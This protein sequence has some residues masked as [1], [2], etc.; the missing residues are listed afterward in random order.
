MDVIECE[1]CGGT[2]VFDA[3]REYARCIFCASVALRPEELDEPPP[4]PDDAVPFAVPGDEAD[5]T[6]RHW[7]RSSW[8]YPKALR[9][10]EI[11][12]QPLWIPAWRF[13]AT[14]EAHYAGLRSAPTRSGKQ[15]L[16]GLDVA[17][18]R[19][20]APASLGLHEDELNALAPFDEATARP[21]SPGDA[22]TLYEVSG[23]SQE[24]ALK[25]ARRQFADQARREL[26][27]ARRL[28]DARVSVA[29]SEVEARSLMLP[30]FIGS[31]RY[32]DRPYRFVING[33]TG[34]ITGKAPIDA[35]KVAIVVAIAL[36]I[37]AAWLWYQQEIVAFLGA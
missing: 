10:L 26:S 3:A 30:V 23:T 11:G 16:S 14:V 5:A 37:A 29:L 24:A 18:R 19:V 22:S 28:G 21:W 33:Q 17:P 36:A 34:Q 9:S 13:D 8:W 15:P 7:A 2:V 4:Q 25:V 27:R 35:R 6:Y 31:F 1:G 20:W 12:L 32:Q